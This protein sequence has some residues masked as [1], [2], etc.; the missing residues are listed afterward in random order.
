MPL[1]YHSL[2]TTEPLMR[3]QALAFYYMHNLSGSN[4]ERELKKRYLSLWEACNVGGSTSQVE[5]A[6]FKLKSCEGFQTYI[7]H[8]SGNI[9]SKKD[10]SINI[11]AKMYL[12]VS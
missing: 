3:D 8:L 7:D 1:T 4:I 10:Y 5:D 11:V 2:P 12:Q 9:I 6:L